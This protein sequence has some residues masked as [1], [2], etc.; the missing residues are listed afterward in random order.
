MR[1]GT[2]LKVRPPAKIAREELRAMAAFKAAIGGMRC[3]VCG[4]TEREALEWSRNELGYALGLQAHHG[5]RQQVLRRLGLPLWD[6][7]LAVPVCEEPCHRRHSQRR[8]RIPRA[9][10]PARLLDFV[11]E[12]GLGLE[13]EKEYPR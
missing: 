1:R 5:I 10:L 4:K 3:V 8:E 11:Q 9:A 12:F 13:L 2:G 6:E 7:R